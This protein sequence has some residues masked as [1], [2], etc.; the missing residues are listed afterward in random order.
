MYDWSEHLVAPES[1]YIIMDFDILIEF[2][3]IPELFVHIKDFKWTFFSH[4]LW[5]RMNINSYVYLFIGGEK[6]T[7]SIDLEII[8]P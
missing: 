1:G 6:T 7:L 8:L 4:Q 3:I 2:E 5:V